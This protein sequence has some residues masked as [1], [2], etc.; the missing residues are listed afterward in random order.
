[1][2]ETGLAVSVVGTVLVLAFCGCASQDAA[3]AR[4]SVSTRISQQSEATAKLDEFVRLGKAAD[5]ANDAELASRMEQ[6]SWAMA[7][8][9][10]YDF[11]ADFDL[12]DSWRL[13]LEKRDTSIMK[14]CLDSHSPVAI[15]LG[16]DIA[17]QNGRREDI[18]HVMGRYAEAIRSGNDAEE[19]TYRTVIGGWLKYHRPISDVGHE[20]GFERVVVPNEQFFYRVIEVLKPHEA[21]LQHLNERLPA[22]RQR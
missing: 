5:A 3:N 16:I 15:T 14:K 4:A 9:G 22:E 19:L 1:M 8:A 10:G 20:G 11:R 2:R 13:W 17:M 12:W 7:L 6:V 21:T 18:D